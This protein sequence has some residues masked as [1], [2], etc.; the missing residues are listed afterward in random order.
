MTT[1]LV[2]KNKESLELLRYLDQLITEGGHG[3]SEKIAQVKKSNG[4]VPV[5][6]LVLPSSEWKN[7][8]SSNKVINDINQI[9]IYLTKPGNEHS[10]S[11]RMGSSSMSRW[12]DNPYMGQELEYANYDDY[13]DRQI[14][15]DEEGR[16]IRSRDDS[17]PSRQRNG[18]DD[19]D[20]EPIDPSNIGKITERFAEKRGNIKVPS[21]RRGRP[22]AP[23]R[24]QRRS[25]QEDSEEEF[26]RRRPAKPTNKGSSKR[27]KKK[28]DDSY[29]EGDESFS[30]SDETQMENYMMDVMHSRDD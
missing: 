13:L 27:N 12:D 11:S 18:G 22:Q 1:L 28:Y 5:P 9:Y 16:A 2:A 26:D 20:D 3:I 24:G 7:G 10:S 19:D 29:S 17:E 14:E 23:E 21:I 25:K 30:D 6:A 8:S 4:K 15:Y